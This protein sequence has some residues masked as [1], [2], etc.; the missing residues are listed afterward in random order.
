[1][2]NTEL[3]NSINRMRAF[4]FNSKLPEELAADLMDVCDAAE[5]QA[6]AENNYFEEF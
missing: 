5:K 6:D 4:V 2:A 1:M 3:Y